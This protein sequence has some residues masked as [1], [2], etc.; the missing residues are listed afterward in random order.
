MTTGRPSHSERAQQPYRLH[1]L[2]TRHG[3]ALGALRRELH[4]ASGQRAGRELAP[5]TMSHLL[6]RREWPSNV[7]A[8]QIKTITAHF[9][10]RHGID[11]IE[12]ALAWE[13]DADPDALPERDNTATPDDAFTAP[14][15]EM[16]TANARQHFKITRPPFIDDVQ[17]PEDLFLSRDQRYVRQSMFE[18]AQH[19][20][21]I[22]V[23][24]ES[25]SGKSTLRRDLLDRIA[26]D[27]VPVIPIQVKA[28]DKSMVTAQHICEAIVADLSNEAPK[29]SLEAKG[30]QVERLLKQSTRTGQRHVLLIEEAHDLTKA[31]LRY[32]KR[33]WELEDGFRR[34]LGIVLIGQPE[35]GD[36]LDLRKN[37]DLR[38]F[39]QRCE[40]CTLQPLDTNLDDYLALKFKRIGLSLDDIVEKGTGDAIRSRLVRAN[41]ATRKPESQCYPL[42]VQNLLVKCM[43]AAA[44][45]GLPRVNADL[46]GRV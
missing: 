20:G 43:N 26:R 44:E 11:E 40:I 13:P 4:Y 45:L 7:D 10:R 37:Y 27:S 3:I 36:L 34:M 2:L 23:I 29:L 38:E 12:I 32:L 28:I 35:L 9:L 1:G 41:P 22:A 17:G 42:I 8:E 21:L 5:S 15:P 16:L 6:R 39:I 18:A 24:G 19:A 46:V 33:F 14:E 31:A 30:R 25:G